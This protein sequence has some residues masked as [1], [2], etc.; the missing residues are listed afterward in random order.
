MNMQ[1]YVFG[2]RLSFACRATAP[3]TMVTMTKAEKQKVT[4]VLKEEKKEK[5]KKTKKKKAE[6]QKKVTKV[7]MEAEKE[8]KREKVRV[9]G[10]T[11]RLTTALTLNPA[12]VAPRMVGKQL[13]VAGVTRT[14]HAACGHMTFHLRCVTT[15]LR[16]PIE[17][18]LKIESA[19][20]MWNT[21][22]LDAD[23]MPGCDDACAASSSSRAR[24]GSAAAAVEYKAECENK[25][26]AE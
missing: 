21:A 10:V 20:E 18:Y 2:S 19:F 12:Y 22:D 5:K 26:A 25:K 16:R 24:R 4:K 3:V 6:K 11:R 14:R 15:R 1:N 8:K 7:L 23:P 9:A 17:L 13:R